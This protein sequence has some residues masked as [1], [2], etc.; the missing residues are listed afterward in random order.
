[1][2]VDKHCLVSY[3]VKAVK[4]VFGLAM[5]S[6]IAVSILAILFLFPISYSSSQ[7]PW[8][9]RLKPGPGMGKGPWSS[10]GQ[11]GKAFDLNLTQDQAKGLEMTQQSHLRETQ[12][13]RAEI[14]SKRLELRELL[15]NP[16]TKT[17]SI[18][19]KY[20]EIASLQSKLEEKIVEYLV[21]TRNLLTPDQLKYWCPE[22]EFPLSRRMMMHGSGL[23][24]PL[25]PI[26]PPLQDGSKEE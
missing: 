21:K 7:P 20:S 15:T 5:K 24:G 6:K 18:R 9:M 1:V 3:P 8:P 16:S 13:L 10:E 25:P 22:L 2:Y 17:E 26:K 23:M 19:A 4:G 12:L 11:C 14:F